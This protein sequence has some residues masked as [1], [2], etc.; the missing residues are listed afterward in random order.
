MCNYIIIN[1]R[2]YVNKISAKVLGLSWVV[3]KFQN[4]I[5]V[6]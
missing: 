3:D 4:C 5:D 2:K 1:V 6:Y